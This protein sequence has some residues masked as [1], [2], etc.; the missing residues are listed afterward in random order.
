MTATGLGGPNLVAVV[1]VFAVSIGKGG[2]DRHG[3]DDVDNDDEEAKFRGCLRKFF[4][5]FCDADEDEKE[6]RKEIK[7]RPDL[8]GRS[9]AGRE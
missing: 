4:S 9:D 2:T 1:A 8:E 5:V 3:D 6:G 7:L